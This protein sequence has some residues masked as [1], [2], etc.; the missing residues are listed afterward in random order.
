MVQDQGLLGCDVVYTGTE[1][2][3]ENGAFAYRVELLV[4]V[5]AGISERSYP[6][7]G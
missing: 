6:F 3:Q 2:F 4:V 1:L 7:Q 5:D